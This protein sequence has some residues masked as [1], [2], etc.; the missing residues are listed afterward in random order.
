MAD[1]AVIRAYDSLRAVSKELGLNSPE[2]LTSTAM[3]K[4][5]ANLTQALNLSPTQLDWVYRHLGHTEDVHLQHYRHMSGF[6]ERVHIGKILLMQDLNVS[7][8]FVGKM[9]EEVDF[10]NI[11]AKYETVKTPASLATQ[12]QTEKAE[13]ESNEP[14]KKKKKANTKKKWGEDEKKELRSLFARNY[15]SKVIP[16]KEETEAAIKKSKLNGGQVWKRSW[17]VVK[18]KVAWELKHM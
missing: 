1:D 6:I 5:M 11:I 18:S 3:R 8:K 15:S 16:G 17:S 12:D 4:Y 9:L 10:S 13:E 7:S 14:P 2:R